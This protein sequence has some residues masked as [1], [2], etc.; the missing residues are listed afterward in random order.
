M[1]PLVPTLGLAFVSFLSSIYVIL[2]LQSEFGLP[3]YSKLAPADKAHLWLA[4]CDLLVLVV[5]LWQTLSETMGGVTSFGI[6]ND[7]LAAIRLWLANTL[8]ITCFSVIIGITLLH[9]RLERPVTFGFSH[10][11][12]WGPVLVIVVTSTAVAGGFNFS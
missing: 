6:A 5:F 11:L 4:G 9:V 3:N 7:P 2:S 8:R 1:I 10:W 12:V